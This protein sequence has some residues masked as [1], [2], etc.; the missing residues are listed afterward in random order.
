MARDPKEIPERSRNL[1]RVRDRHR[2]ARCGSP[3]PVGAWHH[4]RSRHVRD[5]SGVVHSP[6]NGV[7]LCNGCHA[8]VHANPFEA[9]SEGFI[10]SKW[11]DPRE[12]PVK[13]A[14]HGVVLLTMDGKFK[15]HEE[16]A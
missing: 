10:V 5:G 11:A 12:V 9:R 16:E 7:W 3:T 6:A 15:K 4:R 1:V 14:L 13:H 8:T 2:C